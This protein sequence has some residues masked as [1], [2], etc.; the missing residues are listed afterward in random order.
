M[1]IAHRVGTGRRREAYGPPGRTRG[2]AQEPVIGPSEHGRRGAFD[3]LTKLSVR[4]NALRYDCVAGDGAA[5]HG[6]SR[7]LVDDGVGDLYIDL[8]G[9]AAAA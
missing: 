2:V 9:G 7:A 3:R 6:G 1:C 8:E 5:D 4:G